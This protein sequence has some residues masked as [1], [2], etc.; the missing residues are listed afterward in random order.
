MGSEHCVKSVR[1][2]SFSGPYFST[3]GLNTER[4][5]VSLRIQSECGKVRAKKTPNTDTFYAVECTRIN[6]FQSSLAVNN[7]SFVLD[8]PIISFSVE[9][10]IADTVNKKEN[11]A[12]VIKCFLFFTRAGQQRMG[13]AISNSSLPLCLLHTHLGISWVITPKSSPLHIAIDQ[14]C[15]CALYGNLS[16]N[17]E[18]SSSE[19]Y[20]PLLEAKIREAIP[21]RDFGIGQNH[22]GDKNIRCLL[23]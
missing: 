20:C 4:Y 17:T 8:L 6:P 12:K 15:F 3:F 5:S 14:T 9:K 7:V 22:N 13:K 23:R 18:E 2:R 19:L 1:I 10:N 11:K 16:P 21:T